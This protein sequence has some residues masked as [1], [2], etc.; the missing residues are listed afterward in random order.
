MRA[1]NTIVCTG[2]LGLSVTCG[3]A[4]ALAQT[5]AQARITSPS[6]VRVPLSDAR[7]IG[8]NSVRFSA[9]Q[10]TDNAPTVVIF[11][12]TGRN[13]PRL[14]AAIQQ[15]VFE[16]YKVEG[17]FIGPANEPASLEIYAKG[18]HVTRPINPNEITQSDLTKLIRD[19]V[20]EYYRR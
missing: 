8:P 12:L 16:G 1:L 9:A 7:N 4:S 19:V 3:V 20:R 6:Q 17:I 15:A 13:W 10:F 11:G 14:N 5:S 18:H 2:L